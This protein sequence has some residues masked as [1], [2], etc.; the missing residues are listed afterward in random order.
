M[1]RARDLTT[2]QSLLLEFFLQI[3]PPWPSSVVTECHLCRARPPAKIFCVSQARVSSWHAKLFF[4]SPAT[5]KLLFVFPLLR[6]MLEHEPVHFV[7]WIIGPNFSDYFPSAKI[8][9]YCTLMSFLLG[10]MLYQ[11]HVLGPNK[12]D[13]LKQVLHKV[14]LS[15]NLTAATSYHPQVCLCLAARWRCYCIPIMGHCPC[16]Q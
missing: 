5:K 1:V 13:R 11:D 6:Q 4:F 12:A 3:S 2:N 7:A 14:I 8:G 16:L 9:L 10:S 15:M